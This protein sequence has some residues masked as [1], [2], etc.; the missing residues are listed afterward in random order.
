V[1][2]DRGAGALSHNIKFIGHSD[3]GGRSNAVQIMVYKDHAYI[4]Q[5]AYDG[6]TIV[7]VSN[8]RQPVPAA[9][10]PTAPNTWN[11]HLQVHEDLLLVIEEFALNRAYASLADYHAHSIEGVDSSRFGKRGVDYSAGMR[12]YDIS[13]PAEP[14]QIGFL[15]VDGLG[16]HRIWYD[17]GRYAYVSALLDGYTDHIFLIVDMA[18]PTRPCEV[19]R[20][21]LPGMWKAGGETK[22]WTAR[23]ALHHALVANNIAYG[24]WRGGGLTIIDVSDPSR[25]SLLA[26]RN[27][28][29]PFG[30]GTHSALPLPDRDLLLVA[31]QALL[32]ECADQIKYTWVFDVREKQ[33]PVSIATF[34]TPSE[35]D[36]CKVG[37]EFGPHNLHENRKGTFQ[38]SETIFATYSNAGVRAFSIKNPFR[39]EEIGYFVPPEYPTSSRP[40]GLR[41]VSSTDVFVDQRG[42]MY[43][44]DSNAGLDILEF[45]GA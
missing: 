6:F 9:F 32:D 28:S 25:P 13:K 40:D 38:S 29:P 12:V 45:T 11:T 17:G 36:Y 27:W 20:W 14:R 16:V 22:T 39:P 33:N 35:R 24:S 42:L 44:T 21:W 1:T 7:N 23:Y 18:E 10:V 26:Y 31:D 30:G 15:E 41:V 19:G 5:D 34:P 3:L 43:V 8:P 2:S 37:G 4:G